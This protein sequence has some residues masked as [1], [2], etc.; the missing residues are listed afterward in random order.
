M[1]WVGGW[2][3]KKREVPFRWRVRSEPAVGVVSVRWS[4]KRKSSYIRDPRRDAE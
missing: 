4:G 3:G 2:G 1:D